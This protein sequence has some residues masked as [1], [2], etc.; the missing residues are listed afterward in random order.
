MTKLR[1]E[2][3]NNLMKV[4]RFACRYG[5][6][7]LKAQSPRSPMGECKPDS[8]YCGHYPL[9]TIEAHNINCMEISH[10]VKAF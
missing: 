2:N 6:Q 9:V 1:I 7:L 8:D 5:S 3:E 10:K 4:A